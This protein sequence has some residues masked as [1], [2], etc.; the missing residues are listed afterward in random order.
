MPPLTRLLG[1]AH[2]AE[3]IED[4]GIILPRS[5][6]YSY[7]VNAPLTVLMAAVY[8][9]SVTSLPRALASRMPFVSV[10]HDAFR[11]RDATIAFSAVVLGLVVMVAVSALA[12]TS[13]QIFAFA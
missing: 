13:R 1:V 3:E 12:A 7:F 8:C 6:L 2:L 5:M 4:A 10:F 11:D 9:F